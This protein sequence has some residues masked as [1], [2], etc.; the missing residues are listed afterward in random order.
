M[1]LIPWTLQSGSEQL[2]LCVVVDLCIVIDLYIVTD[3]FTAVDL[4]NV[5]L[6]LRKGWPA[7]SCS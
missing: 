4:C 6:Y 5:Y 3:L 7:P 1:R 2:Y